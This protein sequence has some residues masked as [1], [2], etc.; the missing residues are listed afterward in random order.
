MKSHLSDYERHI[1]VSYYF[2]RRTMHEIGINLDISQ[3]AVSKRI[4]KC[5]EKLKIHY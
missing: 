2:E 1:M 3:Q 5:I 4:L